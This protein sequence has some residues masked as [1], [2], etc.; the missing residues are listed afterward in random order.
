LRY[1]RSGTFTGDKMNLSR[2]RK[3]LNDYNRRALTARA[4][5]NQLLRSQ[6]A[7]ANPI[8]ASISV[9]R[10]GNTFGIATAIYLPNSQVKSDFYLLMLGEAESEERTWLLGYARVEQ[11]VDEILPGARIL[12]VQP[13]ERQKRHQRRAA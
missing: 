9:A 6:P 8:E 10:H 4:F 3:K 12:I 13:N 11:K 7:F 1:E 5:N 2:K